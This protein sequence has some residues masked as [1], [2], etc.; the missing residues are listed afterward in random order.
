M[1]YFISILALVVFSALSGC[2]T[3]TAPNEYKSSHSLP[4]CKAPPERPR[5]KPL[6]QAFFSHVAEVDELLNPTADARTGV[7]LR[8]DYKAA[9]PRIQT[10]MAHCDG[11]NGHELAQLYQRAAIIRYNLDDTGGSIDYLKKTLDQSPHI[12]LSL[13]M[14]LTYQVAQL[15]TSEEKYRDGL[16]YF[17]KWEA[18][19][20]QVV[21]DDYF[22]F[23]AQNLYL[24]EL[25][26][27]ALKEI[28]K[29]VKL[30]QDKGETPKESWGKL[31]LA[32]LVDRD[33]YKSALVVAERL[34][35][36]YPTP[37]N[38]SRLASIYGINNRIPDQQAVLDSLS[39]I[40]APGTPE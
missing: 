34:A 11:C 7:K 19:C 25:K 28:R 5:L 15:L 6:T 30:A 9:W 31:E 14:Q 32:I 36:D 17:D 4:G 13:E 16:D 22:Y 26:D 29:S 39:E 38:L 18:L 1:K 2:T 40:N 20:P 35:A 24:M 27:E 3:T 33:D 21:A 12:S 23:R 8:S 10:L 37:V